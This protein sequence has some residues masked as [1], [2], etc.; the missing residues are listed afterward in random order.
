MDHRSPDQPRVAVQKLLDVEE[1]V[2]SPK[3]GLKGNIDA[4]L[5][6][7]IDD[8]EGSRVLTVPFELKTGRSAAAMNHRAQ[9]MLYTLLLSDRYDI[10]IMYGL[11]HYLEKK[12][13]NADKP[14]MGDTIRVKGVKDELRHMII[15]RNEVARYAV[16]RQKQ[17]PLLN[18]SRVCK[19]CYSKSACFTY[20][21]ALEDGQRED[22]GVPELFDEIT[23]HMTEPRKK[24][25][26]KWEELITK[27]ERSYSK[28]R[29]EIWTVTSEERQSRG[30]CFAG[31]QL[32]PGSTTVSQAGAKINRFQYTLVRKPNSSTDINLREAALSEGDPIV[33]SD[34]KGHY[35]LAIGYLTTVTSDSIVVQVD[36]RLHNSLI[37][38]E[39]FD[40]E[41]NQAFSGLKDLTGCSK[42]HNA[43]MEAGRTFRVDKD[44][45]ANG[46]ATLRNNLVQLFDNSDDKR[47]PRRPEILKRLERLR[48]LV[49]DYK[50]P[51][52]STIPT[53]HSIEAS[54]LNE[55]QR[56]AID[57]V[58]RAED[59]ALVLGMPGTGKTT[60]IA[61]IIR[62]LVRSGKSILLTAYTHLAVD[63]IL[64]KLKNDNIKILRVGNS[65]KV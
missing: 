41:T 8:A 28:H 43:T 38:E 29:K 20:Y 2:W 47:N 48:Q 42:V 3:Y 53:Q 7:A 64:L 40:S 59:Y 61:E 25:F 65:I 33:I 60:T 24:Y 55:D 50:E 22:T 34:E 18:D 26:Q 19:N 46:V 11:L 1:H 10:D 58:M 21:K 49:V 13:R 17:P 14:V 56:S 6:V 39:G 36:R 4:T 52:F 51:K 23:S 57:K 27:E 16:H 62:A 63:N 9:T 5:Q 15:Q 35:A 30:T 44:E 31:M 32:V 12:E 45:W 37:K 54:H